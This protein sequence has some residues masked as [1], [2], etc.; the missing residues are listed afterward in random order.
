MEVA[1]CGGGVGLLGC[2]GGVSCDG[3]LEEKVVILRCLYYMIQVNVVYDSGEC[4][5]SKDKMTKVSSGLMYWLPKNYK[6]PKE[7][8]LVL[9]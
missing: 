7:K 8:Y 2:C 3:Y 6:L 1:S 5:E 9:L 4:C